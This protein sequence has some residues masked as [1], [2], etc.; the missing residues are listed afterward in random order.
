MPTSKHFQHR[1]PRIH[2]NHPYKVVPLAVLEE[3]AAVAAPA[4]A[5]RLVYNNGPLLANVQVF[6]LFWGDAWQQDPASQITG[7]INT[8]FDFILTS[9]LMDQLAEYSTGAYKIG[10]GSRSGTLTVTSPAVTSSVDDSAIQQ[11]IQQ[12]ISG[13]T[14]P[15]PNPDSLY[16]VFLPSGVTVTQ[17]GTASCKTFCGY[18][19]AI[20]ENIF[21]AVMPYPDCWGCAS[22]LSPFDAITTTSSHELCEAVTDPIPGQGWYDNNN[23]EIG[24]IC[25]WQTK[26]VGSF[27]VQKE[28]SN[29][30]GACV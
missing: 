1:R 26:Q 29:R 10:H 17:G 18:H 24:D 12:Q 28:W 14:V 20:G 6:T 22:S 9:A 4:P 13:G 11:M 16:F 15:Q 25:A 23:G 21:Y 7:Q 27:T 3:E 19:D 2:G 8:F 5:A 30:A